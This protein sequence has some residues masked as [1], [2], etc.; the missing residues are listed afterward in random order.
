[1]QAKFFFGVS[2]A[3]T[4]KRTHWLDLK[5]LCQTSWKWRVVVIFL[6]QKATRVLNWRVADSKYYLWNIDIIKQ[7][8]HCFGSLRRGETRWRTGCLSPASFSVTQL[9]NDF[10]V[11]YVVFFFVHVFGI[12]SVFEKEFDET[13]L[14]IGKI[15]RV[16]YEHCICRTIRW[17]YAIF[18]LEFDNVLCFVILL[19]NM[20]QFIGCFYF[21]TFVVGNFVGSLV[22]G[23]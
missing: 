20:W 11:I 14:F 1:M 19:V 16:Q 6:P 7:I 9:K 15:T 4:C 5:E 10:L 2:N 23:V 12:F 17:Y 8:W 13:L 21:Q 3:L 22:H 18:S